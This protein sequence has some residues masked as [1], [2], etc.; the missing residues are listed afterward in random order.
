MSERFENS[1][2]C[3]ITDLRYKEV[4]NVNTGM[5]LGC[6]TDALFELNS[7]R[8]VALIVPGACR[9]LGLFGRGD[10]YVIPW[11]CIKRVGDDIIL[12]DAPDD[13]HHG[14]SGSRKRRYW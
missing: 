10:D 3:R 1:L 7:G 4:I 13:F 6:V 11:E 8:I 5:R 9:F 12:V 14:G 2:H